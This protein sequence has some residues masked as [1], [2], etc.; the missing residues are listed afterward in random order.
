MAWVPISSVLSQHAQQLHSDTTPLL[1][2]AE[3]SQAWVQTIWAL[4]HSG[5]YRPLVEY[6]SGVAFNSSKPLTAVH[7][8]EM[9][10]A[11]HAGEMP[12]GDVQVGRSG[13]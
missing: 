12:H 5:P 13:E 8:A 1:G 7:P 9:L 6:A 10:L 3:G 11:S 4:M 2:C